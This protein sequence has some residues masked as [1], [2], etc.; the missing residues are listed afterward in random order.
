[1]LRCFEIFKIDWLKPALIPIKH[2]NRIF[3]TL[4][5]YTSIDVLGQELW[6]RT[7]SIRAQQNSN[8]CLIAEES[9]CNHPHKKSFNTAHKQKDSINNK[10]CKNQSQ[11]FYKF[12]SSFNHIGPISILKARGLHLKF[13]CFLWKN[14]IE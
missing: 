14:L 5:S 12:L 3:P 2:K 1:M 10:K 8:V 9:C 4:I 11:F 13:Q 6:I 7:L